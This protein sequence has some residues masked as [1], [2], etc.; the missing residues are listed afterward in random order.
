MLPLVTS[1]LSDDGLFYLL[2]LD[3]NNPGNY[4]IAKALFEK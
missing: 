4:V 2:V 3:E 1:L